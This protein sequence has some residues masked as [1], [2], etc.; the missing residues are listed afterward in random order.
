MDPDSLLALIL[1][2]Q[3]DAEPDEL[4]FEPDPLKFEQEQYYRG[5][6]G[7][8]YEEADALDNLA[9]MED[10]QD[11]QGAMY[12]EITRDTR[13]DLSKAAD[14]LYEAG[15]LGALA[16]TVADFIP[17]IPYK[18]IIDPPEQLMGPGQEETRDLLGLIGLISSPKWGGAS[19]TAGGKVAAQNY[20]LNRIIANS[21]DPHGY[22]PK[23]G[24]LMQTLKSP[25]RLKSALLDNPQYLSSETGLGRLIPSRLKWGLPPIPKGKTFSSLFKKRFGEDPSSLLDHWIF[26][27]KDPKYGQ[28]LA[29][30]KE[31]PSLYWGNERRIRVPS[32]SASG[33]RILNFAGNLLRDIHRLK[34][35]AEGEFW[36]G[37]DL[38]APPPPG[39]RSLNP[40]GHNIM[41]GYNLTRTGP[42]TYTYG[43]VWDW[44]KNR[45]D[46]K[47]FTRMHQPGLE[48][49]VASITGRDPNFDY[50]YSRKLPGLPILYDPVM[51]QRMIAE[52]LAKPVSIM[53]DVKLGKDIPV[54]EESLL[55]LGMR[56]LGYPIG[57][58]KKGKAIDRDRAQQLLESGYRLQSAKTKHS[59]LTKK[60]KEFLEKVIESDQPLRSTLP[61]KP[62]SKY[63]EGIDEKLREAT[64]SSK[65]AW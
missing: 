46:Q 14:E 47:S 44:A 43:D 52:K 8:S 32:D 39:L 42:E 7:M 60:E 33:T 61:T 55:K 23:L 4:A 1:G 62:Y 26:G 65:P 19:L 3:E 30:S 36:Q 49:D 17:G 64:S 13:S 50:S 10:W 18:D 27:P 37:M 48:D 57:K 24:E 53:G 6:A 9:T 20:P 41:A 40:K 11:L 31:S 21:I 59:K 63:L 58:L 51:I 2:L 28:I 16:A 29:F 45:P 35:K 34:G 25:S 22:S 56:H 5:L 54:D 38:G 15:P 12:G